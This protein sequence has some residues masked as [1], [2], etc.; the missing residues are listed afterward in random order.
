MFHGKTPSGA[1]PRRD[2][3][4]ETIGIANHIDAVIGQRPGLDGLRMTLRTQ[5]MPGRQGVS[6]VVAVTAD[7]EDQEVDQSGGEEV[8]L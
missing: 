5:R 6:A 7:L 1:R 8:G 2:V 3:R 4:I